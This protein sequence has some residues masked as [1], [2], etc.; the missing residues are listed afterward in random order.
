MHTYTDSYEEGWDEDGEVPI[1][2]GARRVVRGSGNQA[3]DAA[4]N[5][6]CRNYGVRQGSRGGQI[7]SHYYLS[8]TQACSK[9]ADTQCAA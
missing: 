2:E 9:V 8:R 6:T 5:C 7:E 3:V 4:G 1:D